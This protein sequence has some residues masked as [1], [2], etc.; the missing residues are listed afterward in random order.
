MTDEASDRPVLSVEGLST[1]YFTDKETVHAISDVDLSVRRGE[2]LGIV[3]ESGSGKSVTARSLT[4]M[5][6]SPGRILD[7]QIKYRHPETVTALAER[8]PD[9]VE[10][11][12]AHTESDAFVFDGPTDRY[13]DLAAAPE[14]ALRAVRGDDIAM[15]FQDPLASLN[16]VYTVGN[17]IEELLTIHRDLGDSAATE[18]AVDLLD[19]VGIPDPARR[20]REYPHQF[21]GGMQ[22]R[23]LIAMALACDPE[24]LVCDEPTTA[25]DVT[26]QAQILELLDD[27]Q[28][29]RDLALLFITHDMG[30]IAEVADRVSVMYAGEVVEHAPVEALFEEAAHP[31]SRGLLASIPSQN[32]DSEYLPTIE[33]DVPTPTSE[34]TQCRFAPRCPE[35]FD[36]CRDVH[37]RHVDVGEDR[38]ASCLLYPDD[39]PRERAVRTH[40]EPTAEDHQ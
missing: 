35:A 10:T 16:P 27:L 34:P 32:P 2:T 39:Q 22:Q 8:Y 26:I 15:V 4:G 33:G 17:Q 18:R 36:A 12:S 21:S 5:V 14:A 6:K 9:R 20:L 13:V 31:Y 37:P 28:V 29:E 38:T 11:S 30:V 24:V 23:A 25:L 40:S 19:A 3:G 1:A 7:G